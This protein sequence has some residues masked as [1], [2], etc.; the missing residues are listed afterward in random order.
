MSQKIELKIEA[1]KTQKGNIRIEIN[2]GSYLLKDEPCNWGL[3]A[4]IEV[5][6]NHVLK[7]QKNK[8]L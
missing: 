1:Y 5:E 4:A 2:G 6:I 7:T 8:L 3:I